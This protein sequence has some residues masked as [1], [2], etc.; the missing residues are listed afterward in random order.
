MITY[1][2]TLYSEDE[3]LQLLREFHGEG[4]EWGKSNGFRP[5]RVWGGNKYSITN[6]RFYIAFDGEVPVA[7]AGFEDNGK[8]IV[9]AGVSVHYDYRKN[10]I[11]EKLVSKRKKN[12][13]KIRV[14]KIRDG[15]FYL[16]GFCLV[17]YSFYRMLCI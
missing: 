15:N 11:S 12:S 6:P 9:S 13:L 17:F 14:Q 1:P 4:V 2:S 16:P 5:R 7:Y 3:L 10:K 8:F